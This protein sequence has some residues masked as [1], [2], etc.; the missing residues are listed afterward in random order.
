MGNVWTFCAIDSDTKLVPAYKVGKRDFATANAFVSDVAA[1]LRNRVQISSDALRAYVEAVEQAFG[2]DVD[3]AQIV[4]TYVT[5]PS[6]E[7][8][9]RFSAPDFVVEEI[10]RVAGHPNMA[11]A[12]T[13]D[14]RIS[15]VL[16]RG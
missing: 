11:L 10:I 6:I 7:P 12:S 14:L 4:K 2:A 9:R 8:E 13:I 5:D 3:F 16:S 15:N 1:R